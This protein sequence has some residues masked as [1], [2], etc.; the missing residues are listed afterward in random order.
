MKKWIA[1]LSLM[2]L[3]T[4]VAAWAGPT[5]GATV[6]Q[7]LTQMKLKFTKGQIGEYKFSLSFPD[8]QPEQFYV[9]AMPSHKIVYLAIVD[10]YE[11]AADN[12][13]APAVFRLMADLNYRLTVGK[14]EWDQQAKT[15][16]LSYTFAAE[17]GVDFASF[18][19]AVQTLLTEV[20]TVRKELAK[21]K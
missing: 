14:L 12:P 8:G 6:E 4:A 19:A 17:N 13:K 20:E 10:V 21:V 11:L 2:L 18:K 1:L 16:R 15:I 3:L 7:Y 5:D 9:R